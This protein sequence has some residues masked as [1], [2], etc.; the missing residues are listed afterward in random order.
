MLSLLL[1]PDGDD[2]IFIDINRLV[3]KGLEHKRA[4]KKNSSIPYPCHVENRFECPY[5]KGKDR[6]Q[7]LTLKIY[8]NWLT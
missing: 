3:A 2:P 5:E 7:G 8:L 4:D 6:M 1:S